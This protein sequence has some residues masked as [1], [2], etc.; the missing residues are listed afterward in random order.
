MDSKGLVSVPPLLL[1]RHCSLMLRFHSTNL[2]YTVAN[3][4]RPADINEAADRATHYRKASSSSSSKF[5]L[6]CARIES[7]RRQPVVALPHKHIA[8]RHWSNEP[9]IG[10][11]CESGNIW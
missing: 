3:N 7:V 11:F 8:A 9:Y 1:L 2:H 6:L 10:R 5:I 4:I